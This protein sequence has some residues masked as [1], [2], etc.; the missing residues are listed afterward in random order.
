[1]DWQII[2]AAAIKVVVFVFLIT[3]PLV[4]MSVW[5]ERRVSA[6]IQ[7]RV[8]PNRVGPF[9]LLQAVADGIKFLL[10]EDFTP[11][12]V[13]KG[14][15]WLAPALTMVPALL[16]CAVLPFGSQLFGEKMVIADLDVGPLFVF[17]IASLTVYGIVL[18]GWA[19]NSKY[20]FLGGVRAASDDL[21][22]TESRKHRHGA[23]QKRLGTP[24]ALGRRPQREGI[25]P[26]YSPFHL[27]HHFH[28]FDV[29]RNEPS[30][31]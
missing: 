17:A 25:S 2:I 31:L 16:T 28:C 12:H 14:Y 24:P 9:G 4:A 29:R 6:A 26:R 15:F 13:R 27:F 7:D 23:G 18:A 11:A 19:S 22:R 30:S 20:P 8:G 21:R 10:K 1:M 5:A 3:L